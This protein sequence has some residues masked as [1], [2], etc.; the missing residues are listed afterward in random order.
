MLT[1]FVQRG[2]FHAVA[3]SSKTSLLVSGALTAFAF[4][5]RFY[6][7][8]NPDEV[9]SV[10]NFQGSLPLAHGPLDSMKYILENLLHITSVGST[11]SMYTLLLRN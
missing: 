5:T 2:S 10:F 6:K 1:L 4:L 3:E 8:N 7:I 9:V 11:T